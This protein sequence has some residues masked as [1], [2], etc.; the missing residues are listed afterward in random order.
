M[1]VKD[2]FHAPADLPQEKNPQY[3]LDRRFSV[4]ESQFGGGGEEKHFCHQQ[5]HPT[6]SLVTTLTEVPDI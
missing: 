2:Q 6:H 5:G 1:E 4:P 3:Q